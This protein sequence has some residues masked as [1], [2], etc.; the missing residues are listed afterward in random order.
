LNSSDKSWADA[1]RR[2]PLLYWTAGYGIWVRMIRTALCRITA[3]GR[4][5]IE[6]GNFKCSN[7]GR[8]TALV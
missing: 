8:E 5:F 7:I 1:G 2:Y 4:F 6:E 3:H